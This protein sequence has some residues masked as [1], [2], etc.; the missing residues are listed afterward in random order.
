MKR[1]KGRKIRKHL[2][3]VL[4]LLVCVC[5]PH[6]S[7]ELTGLIFRVEGQTKKEIRKPAP[8]V[9]HLVHSSILKMRCSTFF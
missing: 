2:G 5:P 9:A 6:D 8:F 7:E 3:D 4:G 1:P